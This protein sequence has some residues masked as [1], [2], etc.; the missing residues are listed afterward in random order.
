[1]TT[2]SLGEADLG[3]L[4]EARHHAF[5]ALKALYPGE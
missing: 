4:W 3:A 5:Y 2:T 1:M